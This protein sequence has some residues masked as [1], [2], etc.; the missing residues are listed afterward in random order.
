LIALELKQVSSSIVKAASL[1]AGGR[2]LAISGPSGSG[3][4][5]LLNAIAGN[6]AY[7]RRNTLQ[8]A[9]LARSLIGGP[10]L[11]LLD[12]P[13]SNLDRALRERLWDKIREIKKSLPVILVSHEPYETAA[14]ADVCLYMQGGV[15]KE[16]P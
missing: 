8:R 14:L 15:L 11:L 13:F 10:K 12:E 2:C 9:A 1:K 6:L 4:T 7:K 16:K 3:K 5:T